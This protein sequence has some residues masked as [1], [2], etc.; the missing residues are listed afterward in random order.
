ME[1]LL[2]NTGNPYTTV[3]LAVVD[4]ASGVNAFVNSRIDDNNKTG[5]TS[6]LITCLFIAVTLRA[7]G[8]LGSNLLNRRH[9]LDSMGRHL[10]LTPL[11]LFHLALKVLALCFKLLFILLLSITVPLICQIFMFVVAIT[12][13]APIVVFAIVA[14]LSIVNYDKD[15]SLR[16]NIDS[17][18]TFVRNQSLEMKEFTTHTLLEN[19][20]VA[21]VIDT[22]T[23][24]LTE[25]LEGL[26]TWTYDEVLVAVATWFRVTI[27]EAWS[28]VETTTMDV[29]ARTTLWA[30]P[31]IC[32]RIPESWWQ[33][34]LIADWDCEQ[35]VYPW[36]WWF[37]KQLAHA[38]FILLCSV[39]FIVAVLFAMMIALTD[40]IRETCDQFTRW[41]WGWQVRAVAAWLI[42]EP[43]K[44][45]RFWPSE[46]G[47]CRDDMRWHTRSD[48]W[49]EHFDSEVRREI[50]PTLLT[51]STFRLCWLPFQ[52]TTTRLGDYV[53]QE[54]TPVSITAECVTPPTLLT[55]Q[56]LARKETRDSVTMVYCSKAGD[57]S[58]VPI[59]AAAWD[60]VG[61]SLEAAMRDTQPYSIGGVIRQVIPTIPDADLSVF[62]NCYA[63]MWN[64]SKNRDPTLEETVPA[65]TIHFL[66]D[67]RDELDAPWKPTGRAVMP[68]FCSNPDTM[69]ATGYQ[70]SMDAI[71]ARLDAVRNNR[72]ALSSF[73]CRCMSEFSKFV[74]AEN[75]ISPWTLDMVLDHQDGPLQKRR[76]EIDKW[77][78][79][80]QPD[81]TKIRAMVK[82]EPLAN[83][84]HDRNIAT[85]RAKY[86][87]AL[88][89]ITMAT[90][91]YLKKKFKWYGAGQKPVTIAH[92]MVELARQA[93]TLDGVKQLCAADVSKM[94][95]AKH[96]QITVWLVTNIMT[97]LC[98]VKRREVLKLCKEEALAS[99]TTSEGVPYAV[100]C[101]QLS[102][103]P[104]TTLANT[105]TNAF[106]SYLAYRIENFDPAQ[107]FGMLGIYVG[108]DSVSHNSATSIVEAGKQMGYKVEADMFCIGQNVPFL[109]RYFYA[110]WEG[111][112]F[113]VQDPIRLLRKL[114]L[115]LAPKGVSAKQAAADKARGIAELDCFVV[116]YRKLYETIRKIT[117][118][119]GD[120]MRGSGYMA[121]QY[122]ADGGWP[123]DGRANEIWASMTQFNPE[124]FINWLDKVKTW[125]QFMRGPGCLVENTCTPKSKLFTDPNATWGL[126]PFAA[127]KGPVPPHATAARDPVD[128]PGL[129]DTKSREHQFVREIGKLETELR[130]EDA[131]KRSTKTKMGT[132]RTSRST[133]SSTDGFPVVD[134]FVVPPTPPDVTE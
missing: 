28:Y 101:S 65:Q 74:V 106:M 64:K 102:G 4:L 85:M 120:A 76:N 129:Q 40:Y 79:W 70:A 133:T 90:S 75:K 39:S 86:V 62:Q 124:I 131:K 118:L 117:G 6:V 17:G 47:G 111:G 36:R 128:R 15:A 25:W 9:F 96:P 114:H 66:G 91:E 45:T 100:A 35:Y 95:A 57:T 109:S 112:P 2:G 71:N 123:S 72:K 12:K 33:A 105:I 63:A 34:Q 61:N 94:D 13:K 107:S 56:Y 113:S 49:L 18:L 3:G 37:K 78:V 134:Q 8:R 27:M 83:V 21:A 103:S 88:S 98:S 23:H 22:T 116:F 93:R 80:H 1:V 50:P 122:L 68:T 24:T 5:M 31:V 67:K 73:V 48:G 58:C 130:R 43:I 97:R 126:V 132:P 42:G 20:K 19:P 46:P 69:P 115:S 7:L 11:A 51:N 92:R 89:T 54:W 87:L 38:K 110:L 82:I 10:M 81:K 121:K 104:T 52:V 119:E 55:G 44:F 41:G 125:T 14:A 108:D 29:I 60:S 16:N 84:N 77:D 30:K 59:S 32:T 127:G 53:D 26:T 99:A